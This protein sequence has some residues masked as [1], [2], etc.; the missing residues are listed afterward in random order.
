MERSLNILLKNYI[1]NVEGIIAV[2]I[3][4]RNGL[5]ITS[6]NKEDMKEDSDAVI[7]AISSMLDGYIDRI[8]QEFDTESSFFNITTTG[9]KKFAFCSQG[10][11][12]IL[13]TLSQPETSDIKLKVFS[14]HIAGKVELLLDRKENVSLEI[15]QIIK[16]L[17]ETR[18]GKLPEGEFSTKL[19][20]IG[21]FQ[22]GKTSL[23]RRFVK[24][25]FL[26]DYTSTIGVDITKHTEELNEKTS[27]NFIIWDVG[28][29]GTFINYRK[30]FYNGAHC[31]MIVVDRTRERTLLSVK[32]WHDDITES[33][34]EKI[35][36]VIVGN[37]SDRIGD[38]VITEED[39]KN[40]S[41]QY[42]YN[43]ILTSAKTGEN[44]NEA[45]SY[46][47]HKVLERV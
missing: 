40:I 15:P 12:S 19:I 18:G 11:N 20:L 35:P 43:Y 36:M 31:A 1:N 25:K 28:G 27:V 41:D 6:E 22:V 2:A 24:K 10:P 7:G 39:I 38:I 21:D 34:E 46:I 8:K 23:I 5:I 17:S 3:V 30:K 26:E 45:F 47:A 13:T 4:D 29:Q 9:D 42:D 32:K 14:E 44:V 16:V 33:I 37:K